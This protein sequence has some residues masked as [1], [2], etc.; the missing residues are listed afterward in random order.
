[1][2]SWLPP[3]PLDKTS[4]EAARTPSVQCCRED[5]VLQ[6]KLRRELLTPFL[7]KKTP[8]STVTCSA[9]CCPPYWL[10]L[11]SPD[12]GGGWARH[13]LGYLLALKFNGAQSR[14]ILN[15]F[16]AKKGTIQRVKTT[17][18][19]LVASHPYLAGPF[20]SLFP[21]YLFPLTGS[22]SGTFYV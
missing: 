8:I 7:L 18:C 21:I 20:P 15:V 11:S 3:N 14:K 19:G 9:G 4:C 17:N 1:M 16:A 6:C 12:L 13:F 10:S 22:T 5:T 2:L